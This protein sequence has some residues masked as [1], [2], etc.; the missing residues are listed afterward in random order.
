MGILP[1]DQTQEHS[2]PYRSS[3][4][5]VFGMRQVFHWCFRVTHYR[6]GRS[7]IHFDWNSQSRS[8]GRRPGACSFGGRVFRQLF[9]R[10]TKIVFSQ[11]RIQHWGNTQR[12]TPTCGHYGRERACKSGTP[13]SQ[14]DCDKKVNCSRP[15]RYC[16][17]TS[18]TV[19]GKTE[20][21]NTMLPRH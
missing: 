21:T 19:A 3:P 6:D 13:T 11:S 12:I 15:S 20:L 2:L 8:D 1:S 9:P 18:H 16:Q 10:R 4:L 17:L 5:S 7:G 14:N